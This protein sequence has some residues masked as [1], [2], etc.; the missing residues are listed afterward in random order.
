MDL[1]PVAPDPGD[2]SSVREEGVTVEKEKQMLLNHS[3]M[4][5]DGRVVSMVHE[6]LGDV[7]T[8]A[9]VVV[10]TTIAARRM[11]IATVT[12]IIGQ[13]TTTIII[14][15]QVTATIIVTRQENGTR[16]D[17]CLR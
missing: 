6:D 16:T 17:P 5:K 9:V 3:V 1:A 2:L 15:A 8:K 12:I 7:A 13:M 4:V 10:S 14:I 11:A